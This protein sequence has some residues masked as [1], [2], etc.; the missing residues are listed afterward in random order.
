MKT[1]ILSSLLTVAGMFLVGCQTTEQTGQA[2]ANDAMAIG[3]KCSQ[4]DCKAYVP[5]RL[6]K[7]VCKDCGHTAA[8]HSGAAK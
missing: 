7:G 3:Q 5:S 8:E 6:I 2:A 1:L 4:C